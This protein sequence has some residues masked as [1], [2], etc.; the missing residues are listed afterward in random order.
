MR[1]TPK[2]KSTRLVKVRG[3]SLEHDNAVSEILGNGIA[4][5]FN[6]TGVEVLFRGKLII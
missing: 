3:Q 6:K 1:F 2:G 4:S 5:L